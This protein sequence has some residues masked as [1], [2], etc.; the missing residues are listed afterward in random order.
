MC[1]NLRFATA[2]KYPAHPSSTASRVKD[3]AKDEAL[4]TSLM[5]S[6]MCSCYDPLSG[7]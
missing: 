6:S 7:F 3:A 2:W 5:G 4:S 1:F